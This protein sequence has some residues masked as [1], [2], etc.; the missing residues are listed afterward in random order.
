MRTSALQVPGVVKLGYSAAACNSTSTA[1]AQQVKDWLKEE[2]QLVGQDIKDREKELVA[3]TEER[4]SA[5]SAIIKKGIDWL[6]ARQE[7]L[8]GLL[9]ILMQAQLVSPAGEPSQAVKRKLEELESRMDRMD[10]L[11]SR[12]TADSS[13]RTISTQAQRTIVI[14]GKWNGE[15]VVAKSSRDVAAE[16]K[17]LV[18]LAKHGVNNVVRLVDDTVVDGRMWLIQQPLGEQLPDG[19]AELVVANTN[20]LAGIIQDMAV[21]GMLHGDI[22]YSN[23]GYLVETKRPFFLD[24]GCARMLSQDMAAGGMVTGTPQFMSLAAI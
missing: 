18:Y 5:N 23:I 17:A 10:E 15:T 9:F 14:Q 19:P 1:M 7:R 21:A 13:G 3:A 20:A 2:L 16:K 22:A 4:D 8:D 11:E 24:F 12:M 6:V